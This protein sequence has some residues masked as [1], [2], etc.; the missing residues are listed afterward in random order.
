MK[1]KASAGAGVYLGVGPEQNFTY[2]A[3]LEPK[4]RNHEVIEAELRAFRRQPVPGDAA[5]LHDALAGEPEEQVYEVH[6]AAQDHGVVVELASP[7]LRDLPQAP[8]VVVALEVVDAP[9]AA[10]GYLVA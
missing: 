3:A 10:G 6:S 9:E 4:Q 2:S 5:D 8:V 1:K 7:P